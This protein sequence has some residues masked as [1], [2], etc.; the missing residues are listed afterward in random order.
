MYGLMSANIHHGEIK[1]VHKCEYKSFIF[2][3]YRRKKLFRIF[4]SALHQLLGL[5]ILRAEINFI[6]MATGESKQ[7][8]VTALQLHYT[9]AT[10]QLIIRS[11]VLRDVTNFEEQVHVFVHVS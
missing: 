7:C 4:P 3:K 11:F 2:S 10:C 5:E 1:L 8:V 9:F 6:G